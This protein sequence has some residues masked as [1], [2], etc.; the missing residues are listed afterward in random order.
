[1]NVD[2][3]PMAATGTDTTSKRAERDRTVRA[4]GRCTTGTYRTFV[5]GTVSN[6]ERGEEVEAVSK[7]VELTCPGPSPT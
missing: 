5:R 2:R 1:M 6:G 3:Q 4:S 7:P